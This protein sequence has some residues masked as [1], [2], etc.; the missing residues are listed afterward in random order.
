MNAVIYCQKP[1][2][3]PLH[4]FSLTDVW[5]YI[6]GGA[7]IWCKI[8]QFQRG[9]KQKCIRMGITVLNILSFWVACHQFYGHKLC[10]TVLNICHFGWHAISFMVTNCAL[11]F[12]TFVILGGMPSVLWSQTVLYGSEHLSFREASHQFYGHKLCFTARNICHFGRET[13]P[14]TALP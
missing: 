6:A 2:V 9:N 8:V 3:I 7:C 4:R 1:N 10:F 12:W 11:R 13:A 14:L 5:F